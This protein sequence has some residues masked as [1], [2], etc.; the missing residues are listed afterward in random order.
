MHLSG[1]PPSRLGLDVLRFGGVT[2]G[3]FKT[4]RSI[5]G[6]CKHRDVF[7]LPVL[8]ANCLTTFMSGCHVDY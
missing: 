8:M 5:G 4:R 7:S 3:P 6:M 1:K 2:E